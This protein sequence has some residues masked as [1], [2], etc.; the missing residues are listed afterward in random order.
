MSCRVALALILYQP[1]SLF[2]V[3]HNLTWFRTGCPKLVYLN[4][5]WCE[6]VSDDGLLVLGTHLKHLESLVMQ[7]CLHVSSYLKTIGS[8]AQ[9]FILF[10]C[11]ILGPSKE[12]LAPEYFR[13]IFNT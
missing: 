13:S 5:S 6:A 8:F 4:I 1:F 12:C 3:A 9:L 7:G 11:L 10:A 2:C